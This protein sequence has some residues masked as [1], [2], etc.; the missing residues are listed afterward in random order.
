MGI[1]GVVA[2][3]QGIHTFLGLV[4]GH[5][6]IALSIELVSKPFDCLDELNE[7]DTFLDGLVSF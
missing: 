6:M 5:S 4:E 1:T 7:V 2:L 3:M